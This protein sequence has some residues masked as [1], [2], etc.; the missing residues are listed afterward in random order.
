[1]SS[2]QEDV[3]AGLSGAPKSLPSKYLYDERGSALFEE[4]TRLPEYYPTRVETALLEAIAPELAAQLPPEVALLEFGSGSSAKTTLLLDA[5][6]Q[7]AVYA[8]IDIS[9]NALAPAIARLRTR[10]PS[11]RV[12]PISADFTKSFSLPTEFRHRPRVGFFPGSTI[13]NFGPQD[14]VAFLANARALLGEGGRFIV[15][16][17]LV[18]EPSVLIAAYADAQGVTAAFNLNL[19]ARINRELEA[20]FD[21]R[22]FQHEAVWNAGSNRIEMHLVSVL[23]QTAQVASIPFA[24]G[25]CETIH[26]ES[27]HKYTLES[28]AHLAAEAGWRIDRTWTAP[29]PRFAVSL[30][31]SD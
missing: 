19:L 17:D 27:S 25:E 22:Y 10:Y 24:F 5:A 21:L 1:M 12:E 8:P 6:P 28:F 9:P 7:I 30:L 31:S 20:D 26:T 16:Y 13:G 18:K 14:A 2:F 3:I 4:I 11:L 23:D 15:G 29:P